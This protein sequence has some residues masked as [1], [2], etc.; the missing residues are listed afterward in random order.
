MHRFSGR[1]RRSHSHSH[2]HSEPATGRSS[3]ARTATAPRPRAVAP[4]KGDL[5]P[6]WKKPVG[7]SHSSPVV[8][9]GLVY[10][11]YQPKGKNA[12]ALAAFDAKTG[13]LKWE[14]SYDRAGVQ[15]A[16]RQR[17]AVD[18]G[19]QRREGLHPRRHRHPRVLG[20]EDRR[21]RLEGGHAQGVQREEPVLRRLDLAARGRRRQ[22]RGDGRRQGG[23]RGRV[24]RE[25]RQDRVAGDRRPGQ[26]RVAGA[27]RT[28]RLV[29]LTGANLLGLSEKG[30]KLWAVPVQGSEL[31][32]SS[33]TPLVVG[34]L[35]IGSS[36]TARDDRAAG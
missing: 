32:E 7:E 31:N 34:D 23:G 14:K 4:W 12:D 30:E 22:G 19:R 18:A 11:F 9:G 5:K 15:A 29:T 2:S 26:L 27:R 21:H 17:P 36:V 33:T 13:E 6:L 8:A 24:R 20:R 35:V 10:A 3:S 1:V 28:S 16:L 25:D